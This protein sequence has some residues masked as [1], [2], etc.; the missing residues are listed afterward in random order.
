MS[1][2][3][4]VCAV[5]DLVRRVTD[6][7]QQIDAVHT[8]WTGLPHVDKVW[9]GERCPDLVDALVRIRPPGEREN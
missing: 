7:E 9:L 5:L 6:T 4:A 8:A 1:V 2:D 3:P